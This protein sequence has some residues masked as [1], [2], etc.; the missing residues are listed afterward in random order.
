M[1]YP[2]DYIRVHAFQVIHDYEDY[3]EFEAEMVRFGIEELT[4]IKDPQYVLL[5][6]RCAYW[7]WERKDTIVPYDEFCKG[8]RSDRFTPKPQIV[9]EAGA[10]HNEM[11][12]AYHDDEGHTWA[13]TGERFGIGADR[14]RKRAYRARRR[15]QAGARTEGESED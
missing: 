9:D 1:K 12:R 15:L 6:R 3:D 2:K 5:C 7:A 14:A 8:K 10:R 13:E 4:P 11:I